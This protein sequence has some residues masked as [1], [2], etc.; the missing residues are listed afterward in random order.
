M[1]I[2]T[3]KRRSLAGFAAAL[4]LLLTGCF[5][6]PGK[7]DSE[8][9]LKKDNSF[10]F[11]YDGEILFLGLTQLAKM[12]AEAD[13]A[14]TPECFD[15][16]TFDARDCTEE[17]KTAQREEWEAGRAAR[18]ES[19]RKKAEQLSKIMGGIDPN[20]PKA[21]EELSKLLLR[22]KGWESV[23]HKGDGVFEVR[24]AISGNATHDFAFPTLERIA[25]FEPFVQF[26]Q[27]KDRQIRVE[28]PRFAV[29]NES[30][31]F[32]GMTGGMAGLA[33]MGSVFGSTGSPGEEKDA[34]EEPMPTTTRL[35]GTFSIVTDGEIL[36][37]NTD[38]GPSADPIGRR[39]TWKISPSTSTPPTAL[40]ALGS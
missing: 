34:A 35:E 4:C 20:D 33:A 17:E 29:S 10:S 22:H 9:V 24:F 3:K 32:G 38:E 11:R 1:M 19:E 16:E 2:E 36:A 27:R 31:P 5:V 15:G 7:F 26:I 30:E 28:A 21:A 12:G 39:L 13:S 25:V 18:I 8:L 6:T 14:F 23:V 40:I 37:N